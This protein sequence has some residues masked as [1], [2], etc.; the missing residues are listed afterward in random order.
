M[1]NHFKQGMLNVNYYH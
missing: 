1:C